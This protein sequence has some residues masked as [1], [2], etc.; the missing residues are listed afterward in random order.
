MDVVDAEFVNL[1]QI[2][3]EAVDFQLVLRAHKTFLANILRLSMIDNSSIQDSMDKIVHI[4]I[5]FIALYRLM[6]EN[7]NMDSVPAAV[8][9]PL[10]VPPEEL[11]II[12]KEFYA[13]VGYLFYLMRNLDCKGFMF[14]LDFNNFMS[15]AENN[16]V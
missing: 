3:T 7:E 12:R 5:R 16:P 13:Q 1:Q 6:S 8:V 2:S 14:R 11:S 9:P 10:Y 4:C 15:R